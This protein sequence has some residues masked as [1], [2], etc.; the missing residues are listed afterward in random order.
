MS[1]GL[2]GILLEQWHIKKGPRCKDDT[3]NLSQVSS[4]YTTPL[5]SSKAC[6]YFPHQIHLVCPCN[7]PIAA[8][9]YLAFITSVDLFKL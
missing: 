2:Q 9:T 3:G 1:F 6:N 5:P 4:P 8:P 7:H